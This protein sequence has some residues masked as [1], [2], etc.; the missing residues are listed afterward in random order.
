MNKTKNGI[1]HSFEIFKNVL[2]HVKYTLKAKIVYLKEILLF[3][4]FI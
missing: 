3:Y 4:A 2:F 1:I